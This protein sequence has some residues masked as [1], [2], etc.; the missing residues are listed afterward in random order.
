MPSC[1]VAKPGV[2]VVA[3]PGSALHTTLRR[4]ARGSFKAAAGQHSCGRCGAGSYAAATGAVQCRPC[5]TGT[6]SNA[7]RTAC[8][9][10]LLSNRNFRV[11]RQQ[12]TPCCK[13]Q[14]E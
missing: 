2:E 4:C 3:V 8:G 10:S 9:A 11:M 14:Q 1:A 12:G 6:R 5:A 13:G 7:A